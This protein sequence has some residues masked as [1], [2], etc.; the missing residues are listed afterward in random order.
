MPDNP[1]PT[2][3]MQRGTAMSTG[4]VQVTRMQVVVERATTEMVY[5][6]GTLLQPRLGPS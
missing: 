3:C 5:V 4:H 6:S 1:I 2:T